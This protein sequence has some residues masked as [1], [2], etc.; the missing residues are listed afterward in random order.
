MTANEIYNE[1]LGEI[2]NLKN[3]GELEVPILRSEEHIPTQNDYLVAY[4]SDENTLSVE[5][6]GKSISAPCNIKKV[7]CD[8]EYVARVIMH[9]FAKMVLGKT[10]EN[11]EKKKETMLENKIKDIVKGV[12]NEAF[13]G[14]Y[15]KPKWGGGYKKS[16][17]NGSRKGYIQISKCKVMDVN[18]EECLA[19]LLGH[20]YKDGAQKLANAINSSL[21]QDIMFAKAQPGDR[22]GDRAVIY[23]KANAKE[24]VNSVLAKLRDAII[25]VDDYNEQSIDNLCDVI[26]DRIDRLV[27]SADRETAQANKINNWREMLE[28]LQDPSVREALLKYQ[29]TSNYSQLYGHVL[30]PRNI[31]MVLDQKPDA[32]FV[33]TPSAWKTKFNRTIKPGAQRIVVTL[34]NTST[35]KKADLDAAA[36]RGGW[37]NSYDDAK[38]RSGNSTQVLHKIQIAAQSKVYSFEDVIMIDVSDTIP[39]SDPAKDKWTN[40]IGLNDNITGVLNNLASDYDA[41]IN[42]GSDKAKVEK[43]KQKIA[44]TDANASAARKDIMKKMCKSVHLDTM[45][46]DQYDNDTFIARAA[47][48]YAK[49]MAAQFNVIKPDLVNRLA[50]LCSCVVCNT[51]DIDFNSTGVPMSNAYFSN[52]TKEDAMNVFTITDPIIHKLAKAGRVYVGKEDMIVGDSYNRNLRG[53]KQVN[54][55]SNNDVIGLN[56]LL[57]MAAQRYAGVANNGEG[58]VADPMASESFQRKIRSIVKEEI[59]KIMNENRKR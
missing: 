3:T 17:P 57:S 6:G 5:Y 59:T 29:T 2:W 10:N 36:K 37:G 44:K 25:S 24:R 43:M 12:L 14:G 47:Y 46:F 34:P 16:D 26:Y 19:V 8:E 39:P 38:A 15:N 1:V 35:P 11:K 45:P 54:E 48:H 4:F 49:N 52:I 13:Y 40:E 7:E 42:G 23:V 18:G 30:S 27:T 9:N 41:Q 53:M 21:P 58:E 56:G 55:A 50:A 33:T 51:F 32:S 22:A 20:V 28:R 31:K